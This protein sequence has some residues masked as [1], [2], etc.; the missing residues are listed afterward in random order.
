MDVRASA[1]GLLGL[2]MVI[3]TSC[4][5][6]PGL[7]SAPSPSYASTAVAPESVSAPAPVPP[8]LG[9]DAGVV[10]SR[11]LEASEAEVTVASDGEHWS[12][13][14]HSDESCGDYRSDYTLSV[15]T[16]P[17]GPKRT[18]GY[19]G[20]GYRDVRITREI[21]GVERLHCVRV[22]HPL[23]E[24]NSDHHRVYVAGR[25]DAAWY[26]L[27]E[28]TLQRIPWWHLQQVRAIVIDDRPLL[29]GVAPFSRE[30]PADDARDGHTIWLHERLFEGVNHWA[31][32]N[33]GRYW[34]YH[35]QRDGVTVDGQPADHD[36]FS[37]VLLHEIG[38]LVN[39]NVVNGSASDPTC[40]PCARMCGDQ[41]ACDRLDQP[42]R[43][44]P[45]A[46]AYCTGFGYQ[47][48]TENWAEMYRWYYQG[49]TTRRLLEKTFPECYRVFEGDGSGPGINQRLQAPWERGLGEVEGYRRTL[50]KSCGE[51]ACKER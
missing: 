23:G 20:Y 3:L 13:L 14:L 21:D 6:P 29:H 43:E 1:P 50:W 51:K 5:A 8:G 37:P 17:H 49:S 25:I 12:D 44:A 26:R 41:G 45:C 33:Y 28:R 2:L 11:A 40:P 15:Y 9:C 32:G 16:D 36:L 31:P 22:Y 10:D 39:Y 42:A 4:T 27:I 30:A 48:G 47:S 19:D 35:V 34:G 46:T 7:P 18:F 38:H 24:R